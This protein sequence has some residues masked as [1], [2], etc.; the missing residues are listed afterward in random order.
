MSIRPCSARTQRKR[1]SLDRR[2]C[3]RTGSEY[4]RLPVF[5]AIS[6]VD[7][8]RRAWFLN[9]FSRSSIVP[10]RNLCSINFQIE[11]CSLLSLRSMG[12][13]S[14]I[15]QAVTIIDFALF[16]ICFC[17]LESFISHEQYQA[18]REL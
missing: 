4:R 3:D 1:R 16:L 7:R 5:V 10:A 18:V 15:K 14:S 2:R 9:S 8:I 13:Q 17:V 11:N 12:E 6:V